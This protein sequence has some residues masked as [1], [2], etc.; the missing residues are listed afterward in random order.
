MST[1]R[2]CLTRPAY[3]YGEHYSAGAELD[4]DALDAQGL[5]DAQRGR[6]VRPADAEA[7]RLAVKAETARQLSLAA[8][9]RGAAPDADQRW[10]RQ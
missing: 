2:V 4:C 6:L 1:V 10:R 3:L 8:R 7:L 9:S 5:L